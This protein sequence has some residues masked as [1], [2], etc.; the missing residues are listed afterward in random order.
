MRWSGYRA[1]L[2]RGHRDGW[3]GD[4]CTIRGGRISEPVIKGGAHVCHQRRGR[5]GV[6][7][8]KGL[9]RMRLRCSYCT[10][11]GAFL[12]RRLC[13]AS[14]LVRGGKLRNRKDW[15][16]VSGRNGG[17]VPLPLPAFPRE[18]CRRFY[19]EFPDLFTRN[20]GAAAA[21]RSRWRRAR[22]PCAGY[23]RPRPARTDT[24]RP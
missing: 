24:R 9:L 20:A 2:L 14:H 8:D 4:R 19:P 21:A 7:L 12:C 6:N 3:V 10:E 16:P 22:L 17:A 11:P 23:P 5:T 1:C 13:R 15:L 18:I